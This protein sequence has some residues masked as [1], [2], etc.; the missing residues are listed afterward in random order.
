[1]KIRY[2]IRSSFSSPCEDAIRFHTNDL[3]NGIQVNVILKPGGYFGKVEVNI[4]ENEPDSFD[5]DWQGSDPTRFPVRKKA[6]ATALYGLNHF[7][8]FWIKHFDGQLTIRRIK[9][10]S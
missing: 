4:I 2:A 5:T 3:K 8:K 7:G 9:P 1:M 10:I 6:A